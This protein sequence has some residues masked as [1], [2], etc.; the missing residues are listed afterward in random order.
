M[1]LKK[2]LA[3]ILA[4]AIV[5]VECVPALAMI[6]EGGTNSYPE[7]QKNED[8]IYGG[9]DTYIPGEILVCVTG[10]AE[11][12][13]NELESPALLGAGEDFVT[14]SGL[15]L[16]DMQSLY[17]FSTEEELL[18]E[19]EKTGGAAESAGTEESVLSED[20]ALLGTEEEVPAEIL[21]LKA[22][23]NL[24]VQALAQK[25]E[26]L[27]C[28]DFAQPNYIYDWY[29]DIL[30]EENVLPEEET[31]TEVNILPEETMTAE[32]VSATENDN[33][34]VPEETDAQ[35][36]L[37]EN[38]PQT[39]IPEIVKPEEGHFFRIAT[40]APQE[41]TIAKKPA[42]LTRADSPID[43]RDYYV[44][45][46]SVDSAEQQWAYNGSMYG[47]GKTP[48]APIWELMT[49][50]D[51]ENSGNL[52]PG[53]TDPDEDTPED[54]IVVALMD[55]GI[56]TTHPSFYDILWNCPEDL[57]AE[58]GC[59][60]HGFNAVGFSADSDED[61]GD[62]T[63]YVG[64]GTHCAGIIDASWDYA[65]AYNGTHGI[66]NNAKLMGIRIGD[67]Q[68]R[69]LSSYSICGYNFL[70][71]AVQAGVNVVA[72]NNSWGGN[73]N[74]YALEKVIT[75]LGKM[76]TLSVFASGNSSKNL[77]VTSFSA[78]CFGNNPYV[79]TVNA[80]DMYGNPAVFSNYGQKSTSISAPGV[81]IYSTIGYAIAGASFTDKELALS[82][83]DE[84]VQDELYWFSDF[85]DPEIMDEDECKDGLMD[86]QFSMDE[87]A[88]SSVTDTTGNK[89]L[90][91]ESLMP[92]PG[93]Y[94]FFLDLDGTPEFA[95]EHGGKIAMT[96]AP[97]TPQA[98]LVYQVTLVENYGR[99]P[100]KAYVAQAEANSKGVA[101]VSLNLPQKPYNNYRVNIRVVSSLSPLAYNQSRILMDDVMLTS[102][103]DAYKFLSGTSM[104]APAVTGEAAVL[105]GFFAKTACEDKDKDPEND[106]AAELKAR[107][108]G[109]AE[110]L[111]LQENRNTSLT[112]GTA[113][114]YHALIA[115]DPENVG[116]SNLDYSPVLTSATYKDGKIYAKGFFF[117]AKDS[118][119]K[120]HVYL[121]GREI[122]E[123]DLLWIAKED[124]FGSV[125][126]PADNL[127]T[128]E[129]EI[130]IIKGDYNTATGKGYRGRNYFH[131]HTEHTSVYQMTQ[132]PLTGSG[133]EFFTQTTKTMTA[134]NDSLYVLSDAID[135]KLSECG[136]QI[137]GYS[138]KNNDGWK[139]VGDRIVFGDWTAKRITELVSFRGKLE[140]FVACANADG[141]EF[142]IFQVEMDP[143]TGAAEITKLNL[144]Q[145]ISGEILYMSAVATKDMVA[146]ISFDGITA[147]TSVRILREQAE[148]GKLRVVAEQ[149]EEEK[150]YSGR[151]YCGE[152]NQ[153]YYAG[154]ILSP[155][156]QLPVGLYKCLLDET[157][158]R[159][160]LIRAG[161]MFD[162][163][164][165]GTQ[166]RSVATAPLKNGF[167]STG[168]R[169]DRGHDTY[170]LRGLESDCVMTDSPY[171]V[172]DTKMFNVNAA[173]Y[174]GYYYV[175]ADTRNAEDGRKV[176]AKVKLSDLNMESFENPGDTKDPV[177]PKPDPDPDPKPVPTPSPSG[178]GG[179]GSTKKSGAT[180]SKYWF[181]AGNNTWMIKNSAG[182]IVTNAW[183]CDD[184]VTTN[185]QN[186]WYLLDSKGVML[187]AGIV[188]DNTGNYYSL[189]TN[190]NGFYGMLRYQNG[191][192]NCDGEMI[193]LEF[194]Q[195]HNG[196]FAAIKN[197]DGI[198][199]LL[200]HYDVKKFNIGNENCV[201]TTKF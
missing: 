33:K 14:E 142:C 168:M 49:D 199:K 197:A 127:V 184:A 134:L 32:S 123:R 75:E 87:S 39:F 135:E 164:M 189:E 21:L 96:L 195:S 132:V 154:S 93:N 119:L 101:R 69:L 115:G 166:Q 66:A 173:A 149:A 20:P 28:V 61:P 105:A 34:A 46:D 76:G 121:D 37:K 6:A 99:N 107:I 81:S 190:H 157:H 138:L 193:Y 192:Y 53:L 30:P 5:F 25:L 117:D 88:L 38:Q 23:E 26:T 67:E 97:E 171:F 27:D 10:G 90:G 82:Y 80:H 128:G 174:K 24:D 143:K 146:L 60:R 65:D 63:D 163:T 1:R 17:S 106:R 3:V 86:Y 18:P 153:I 98:G 198:K 188:Q 183:L 129:H 141:D 140:F 201:Y 147:T 59:G 16:Y 95:L 179:G 15:D 11:A 77:D 144:P 35:E 71:K 181:D 79:I 43:P 62:L 56:E 55:S 72:V 186:V 12:L 167:I 9:A 112:G 180:F 116:Y 41:A 78:S 48:G 57:Q 151:F 47:M 42:L 120:R 31:I 104:A 185:G 137:W 102:Y 176:F 139:P 85:N 187:S 178:S 165:V 73:Y 8:D 83:Y 51:P 152:N 191:T 133:E 124:R 125:V 126:F 130:M 131:F 145:G 22:N 52:N 111:P 7:A 64:H 2:L 110:P 108:L 162:T 103:A 175:L 89:W 177:P 109:S 29:E 118:T 182:T 19:T 45:D 50:I 92:Q 136:L 114:L 54:A 155:E 13:R 160:S 122:P 172:C 40:E 100:G 170:V 70:K 169:D 196:S 4:C 158:F 194:E 113:N 68:G 94:N 161:E 150:A 84:D 159:C 148:T 74:D 200:Q 91:I 36:L 44:V 58:L 156:E